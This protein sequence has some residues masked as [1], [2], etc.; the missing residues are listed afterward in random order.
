MSPPSPGDQGVNTND[1]DENVTRAG[2]PQYDPQ[3]AAHRHERPGSDPDE[4]H[5]IGEKPYQQEA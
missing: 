2:T 1:T 5:H 3:L 4:E